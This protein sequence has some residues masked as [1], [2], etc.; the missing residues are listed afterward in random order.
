M[1]VDHDEAALKL[2]TWGVESRRGAAD[3]GREQLLSAVRRLDALH[4]AF[5]AEVG[6]SWPEVS[7]LLRE[8]LDAK[9]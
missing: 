1:M 6:R 8:V 3:V 5:V 7:R 4:D 9:R 2:A